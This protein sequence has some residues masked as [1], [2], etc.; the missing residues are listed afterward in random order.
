L[1]KGAKLIEQGKYSDAVSRLETATSILTTNAQA[2][3]YIGLAYHYA[4]KP[5]ES[6]KAYQRALA[7]DHDLSEAHFNLGCL[8][9]EQNRPDAAKTE[10]TAYVLRRGNSLDALLKLGS[11]QLHSGDLNGAEKTFNDA[12]RL[13]PEN[14]DALNGVGLVRLQHRRATEAAQF[15]GRAL[16]Q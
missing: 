4:G 9:L 14:P 12:L 6:E 11:A 5:G 15:F 3:N 2:W 7:L 8:W 13:L 16:K 10:L 1:L